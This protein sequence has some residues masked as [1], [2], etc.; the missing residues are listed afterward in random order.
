MYALCVCVCVCMLTR[1]A[2]NTSTEQA[3]A[4]PERLRMS[5][6]EMD[7]IELGGAAI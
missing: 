3:V 1:T 5:Q 2:S 6:A 7:A 4:P